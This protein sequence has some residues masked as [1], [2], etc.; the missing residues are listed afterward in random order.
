MTDTVTNDR[1]PVVSASELAVH[2]DWSRTY[3]G[4]LEAE[5]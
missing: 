4:K 1:P 3:I 5:G 2:L